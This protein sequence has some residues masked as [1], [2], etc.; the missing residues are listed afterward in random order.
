MTTK[1][2]LISRYCYLSGRLALWGHCAD[3]MYFQ[4]SIHTCDRSDTDVF[5]FHLTDKWPSSKAVFCSNTVTVSLCRYKL[6]WARL[7]ARTERQW[8]LNNSFLALIRNL[9]IKRKVCELRILNFCR[10][11][12]SKHSQCWLPHNF[13]EESAQLHFF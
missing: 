1:S 8:F 5:F 9:G 6:M 12:V 7:R 10:L 13:R 2:A 3:A 4:T 11:T